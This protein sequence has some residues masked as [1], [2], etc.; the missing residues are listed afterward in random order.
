MDIDD[1]Y[2]FA[3][4]KEFWKDVVAEINKIL[5]RREILKASVCAVGVK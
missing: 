5:E 1:N 3:E 2:S 4:D